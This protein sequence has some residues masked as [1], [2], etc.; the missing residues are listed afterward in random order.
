MARTVGIG[1]QDFEKL[2]THDNFYIDKSNF[3]VEWWN[4]LTK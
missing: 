4:S 1:Y 3:I 2:R